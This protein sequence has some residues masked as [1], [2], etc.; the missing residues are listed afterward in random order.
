M[1]S[2]R[3]LGR[4]RVRVEEVVAAG[5]PGESRDG[6]RTPERAGI[7]D[8]DGGVQRS[9]PIERRSI[10]RDDDPD[11]VSPASELSGNVSSDALCAADSCVKEVE[12]H[13][14][15]V[16]RSGASGRPGA[17]GTT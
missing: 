8:V 3:C 11:L 17:P 5:D 15:V 9:K 14:H 2:I 6:E 12:Q 1:S 4:R 7:E 16:T 13:P 10:A